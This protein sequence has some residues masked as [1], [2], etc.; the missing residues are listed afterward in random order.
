MHPSATTR[1]FALLG[2]PVAHSF[3]PRIQNAAIAAAGYD[4]VYVALRCGPAGVAA[5]MR[6]LVEA[7]GGGNVTV[8]HKALAAAALD[9]ATD[10]VRRT[11]ACNTF[12]GEGGR[13]VGD[14]TDV[15]GFAA[16]ASALVGSLEGLRVLLLGAGGAAAAAMCALVYGGAAFVE[17]RNRTAQRAASLADRFAGAR[18]TIAIA[19]DTAAGGQDVN[20]GGA[21]SPTVAPGNGFDLLV[22][23]TSLGLRDDDPLPSALVAGS[24]P[25]LDLVYRVGG[26]TWMRTARRLGV[27]A[28]DGTTMLLVQGAAAF[29]RWFGAPAPLDVM[30]AA[31]GR[32]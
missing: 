27:A 6:A 23:A 14:N 28:E 3:S 20:N 10:A 9:D 11:G 12:W 2:D 24:P 18:T 5:L 8:P 21:A 22:N 7:G 25:L 31:L 4:A 19:A 26:T 16:A 15:A 13:L 1:V 32:G 30:R 29:E 17:I